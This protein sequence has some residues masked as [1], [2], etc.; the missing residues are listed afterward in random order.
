MV[1]VFKFKLRLWSRAILSIFLCCS[2]FLGL[3]LAAV[4]VSTCS[5]NTTQTPVFS[6]S[7]RKRRLQSYIMHAKEE[8]APVTISSDVDL[9]RSPVDISKVEASDTVQS[10]LSTSNSSKRTRV[11]ANLDSGT[12]GRTGHL[13]S[14]DTTLPSA[15][16]HPVR[17]GFLDYLWP[18]ITWYIPPPSGRFQSRCDRSWLGATLRFLLLLYCGFSCVVA[19]TRLYTRIVSPESPQAFIEL[20]ERGKY[21]Q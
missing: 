5:P 13:V 1:R 15:Y 18:L 2:L 19:T 12:C 9:I 17:K 3:F 6:I 21:R 4:Y 14:A 11:T 8:N 20:Q 16:S 10:Y 7:Q